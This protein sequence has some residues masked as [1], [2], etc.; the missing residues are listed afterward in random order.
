[1][2]DIPLIDLRGVTLRRSGYPILKGIDWRLGRGRHCAVL[3]PNGAGKSTLLAVVTGH[4]WPTDGEVH[5]F[6]ERYGGTDLTR[7][8]RRL[9]YVSQSRLPEIDPGRE[10]GEVVLAGRWNFLLVPGW[11]EVRPEDEAAAAERL[12]AVGLLERATTPFGRLSSGEQ[13]RVLL[14][15]ALVA[16]PELLILDEP[17]AGLD[18]VA[19]ARF[20]RALDRLL[21]APEAPTTLIVSHHVEDLPAGVAEVLLLRAGRVTAAGP[22]EQALTAATLTATYGCAIE[23]QRDTAGHYSAQ[24]GADAALWA[25]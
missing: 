20:V 3:G 7:L 6:G 14:A 17:T 10:I 12:R 24:V 15:R 13:M 1:M 19:R 23:L 11:V 9:G 5:V 16:E 8:R 22:V 4:E 2:P 21:A 25:L 18:L